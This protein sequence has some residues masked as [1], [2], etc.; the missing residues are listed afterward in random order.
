MTF[1]G[2]ANGDV[3]TANSSTHVAPN[4]AINHGNPEL[5]N[6]LKSQIPSVPPIKPLTSW[7]ML[8]F[9]GRAPPP[10]SLLI[11]IASLSF[12]VFYWKC[13]DLYRLDF[14]IQT[15]INFATR[16]LSSTISGA[17]RGWWTMSKK[18]P[19]PG[20]SRIALF[21]QLVIPLG[22]IWLEMRQSGFQNIR[23]ATL[24]ENC[25]IWSR[26]RKASSAFRVEFR[27]GAIINVWITKPTRYKF[28]L[29]PYMKF[30]QPGL[31]RLYVHAR[32][33]NLKSLKIHIAMLSRG[34]RFGSKT[35]FVMW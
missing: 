5:A 1:L 8:A 22:W 16:K 25:F 31:Q 2:W 20:C 9:G 26:V 4:G 10:D 24:T 27:S 12:S 34:T 15:K 32:A 23:T 21:N 3:G 19:I 11:I 17:S 33:P 18:D 29:A 6:K 30:E 13:T 14:T 7:L 35:A 28:R